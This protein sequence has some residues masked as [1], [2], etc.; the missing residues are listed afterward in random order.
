[1]YYNEYEINMK[2]TLTGM[3]EDRKHGLA[4]NWL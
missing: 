4:K 3:K 1:M 2:N